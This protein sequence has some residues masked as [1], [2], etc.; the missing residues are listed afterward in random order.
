MF[1]CNVCGLVLNERPE[2]CPKC[3]AKEFTQLAPE[4]AALY[5]KSRETDILYIKAIK[6][7]AKI[8]AVCDKGIEL[9]LDQNC[10]NTFIKMKNAAYLMEQMSKAELIS[11]AAK[12]KF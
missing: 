3:G 9:N 4:A 6:A 5:V 7:A 1:K 11:H 12:G 10:V 2:V 8:Q